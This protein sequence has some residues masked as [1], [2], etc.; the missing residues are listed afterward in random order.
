M[1]TTAINWR[2]VHRIAAFGEPLIELQPCANGSLSVSFG[3][4]VANVLVC[5][6][7]I[8][9]QR[10]DELRVLTSLGSS[11]YSR[12][13]RDELRRY[14]IEVVGPNRPGEPGIYGISPDTSLQPHS[15]YWRSESAA[16][17]FFSTVSCADLDEIAPKSDAV[18]LSGITLSLCSE[19][20]FEE[21]FQWTRQRSDCATVVLDCNYRPALWKDVRE[22]RHRIERFKPA[23]SLVV[24]SLEDE[25][26]LWPQW[27]LMDV[28]DR[29]THA[30][31]EVVVRAGKAG[32]WICVDGTW[33]E[34]RIVASD[35][36]DATG[37]GDS[38][39]AGYIAAR[40][41][42]QPP[43]QAAH[44]ANSVARVIIAQRGSV[45]S[46]RSIFPAL[47]VAPTS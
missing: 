35:V 11:L 15:S 25:S 8:L 30:A 40:L 27:S 14:G 38:H 12:W 34:A 46:D 19:N 3:G 33:T 42:G 13:L 26:L 24:T 1:S 9:G 44:Y 37:A 4:D 39:L 41:S 28:L 2:Q 10:I 45:P 47:P 16:R 20:S 32:C 29:L 36:V 18:I 21:L 7:R 43:L 23:A 6:S 17:D 5:L 31:S 22:A